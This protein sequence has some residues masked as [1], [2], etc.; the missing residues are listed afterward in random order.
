M[1]QSHGLL[2][3]LRHGYSRPGVKTRQVG[4]LAAGSWL[5]LQVSSSAELEHALAG[6]CCR[7]RARRAGQDI[8][9]EQL[10]A[11]SGFTLRGERRGGQMMIPRGWPRETP[12]SA[13]A[14][15][16]DVSSAA[17]IKRMRTSLLASYARRSGAGLAVMRFGEAI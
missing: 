4:G 10:A 12:A 13:A 7:R 5:V 14:S 1:L 16:R 2:E 17:A 11:Q 3:E 15:A 6:H 8:T 9:A